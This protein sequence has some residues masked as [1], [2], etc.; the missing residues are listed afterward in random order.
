MFV[1]GHAPIRTPMSAWYTAGSAALGE[2]GLA[3]S[4]RHPSRGSVRGRRDGVS[5]ATAWLAWRAWS[6]THRGIAGSAREGARR[7]RGPADGAAPRAFRRRAFVVRD[8]G[9][10]G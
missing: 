6:M 5:G 7:V 1:Q 10:V 4:S 2:G 3:V 8:G 9:G